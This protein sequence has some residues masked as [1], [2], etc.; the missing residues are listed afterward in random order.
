MFIF[1]ISLT[2]IIIE[3][4][5]INKMEIINLL[6]FCSSYSELCLFNSSNISFIIFY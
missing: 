1:N 6:N 3:N 5:N 2:K 4:K